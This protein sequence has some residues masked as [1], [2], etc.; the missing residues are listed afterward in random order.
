VNNQL[1]NLHLQFNSI[2]E[3]R[4]FGFAGFLSIEHIVKSEFSAVPDVPGV[5]I[6]YSEPSPQGRF[7]TTSPA[8]YH[9][10]RDPTIGLDELDS[11]WVAEACV[12]Y[13]GKAGGPGM[14]ATLR[15]RIRSYIRHGAGS[16]AG[17]WGGRAIWQL[18]PSNSIKFAWMPTDNPRVVERDLIV[19]FE[20]RHGRRPFAN[21]VS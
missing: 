12:L 21:R 13:I 8:G 4:E 20:Q 9:K 2:D 19:A 16:S 1:S 18:D 3:L 15:K 11:R 6:V 14:A 7:L 17:H 10:G 5:Y